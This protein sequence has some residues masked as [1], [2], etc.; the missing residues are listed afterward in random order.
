MI[1]D[2]FPYSF[3]LRHDDKTY[4]RGR[5]R[6]SGPDSDLLTPDFITN[7]IKVDLEITTLIL[8]KSNRHHIYFKSEEDMLMYQMKYI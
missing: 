7:L 2:E 4:W 3:I 5:W 1:E 6:N 8:Y